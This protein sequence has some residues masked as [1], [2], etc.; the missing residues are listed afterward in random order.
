M[1]L[2]ELYILWKQTK[3]VEPEGS[4]DQTQWKLKTLFQT[5]NNQT[6]ALAFLN[7]HR[8]EGKFFQKLRSFLMSRD[9]SKGKTICL[10]CEPQKDAIWLKVLFLQASEKFGWRYKLL[11]SAWI[12]W[13]RCN[14]FQSSKS[15]FIEVQNNN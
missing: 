2:A 4:S 15:N 9:L 7:C 6:I 13:G 5:L 10:A 12:Y 8:A 14:S 1:A 11:P 3:V